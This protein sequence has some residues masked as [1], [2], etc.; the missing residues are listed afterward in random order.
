MVKMWGKSS[1]SVVAIQQKGKPWV[2]QCHIYPALYLQLTLY[3]QI[4]SPLIT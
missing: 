1:R 4:G 3:A 2:L